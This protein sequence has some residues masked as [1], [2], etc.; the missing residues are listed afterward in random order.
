[1]LSCSGFQASPL[2]AVLPNACEIVSSSRHS[3]GIRRDENYKSAFL[4]TCRAQPVSVWQHFSRAARRRAQAYAR[5]PPGPAPLISLYR[6]LSQRY[7][8]EVL[9]LEPVEATT[10]GDHRYDDKLDDVSAAGR[11]RRLTRRARVARSGPRTGRIAAVA[12]TSGRCAIAGEPPRVRHMGSDRPQDWAG[13][14]LFTRTL[15]AAA[16]TH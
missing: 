8:D 12:R 11:E 4:P 13:T 7:F 15:R 14:R 3:D 16:S 9:A 1:M 2:D 6:S 5:C 10:L